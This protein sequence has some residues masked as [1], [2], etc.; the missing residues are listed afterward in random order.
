[1]PGGGP[2]V[3]SPGDVVTGPNGEVVSDPKVIRMNYLK[4]WFVVDLL[5]CLP[6]D[7]FNAFQYVDEVREQYIILHVSSVVYNTACAV[8][9]DKQPV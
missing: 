1:M 7:V 6:Y 9:G 3:P 2:N 8:S 5:S 4:T